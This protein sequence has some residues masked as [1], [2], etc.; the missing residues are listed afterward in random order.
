MPEPVI[1]Q[2]KPPKKT[3]I[4]LPPV[5]EKEPFEDL[6]QPEDKIN[7]PSPKGAVQLISGNNQP[8]TPISSSGGQ[9]TQR[10]GNPNPKLYGRNGWN[11]GVDI[12]AKPGEVQSAPKNGNWV[13]VSAYNKG[14]WNSGWG[15][16]VVMQ[17]TKTGETIR[18]SHLNRVY[19]K[20]G[21]VITGKPVGTTGRTGRTTGYHKDVEYT[22]NGRLSDYTKSP[23]YKG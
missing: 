3:K 17:N 21:Q 23:Y 8:I 15:N 19:V 7:I 18:R 6:L 12:S 20:K 9:I 13:V 22:R 4:V 16:S 14:G 1:T 11:R 2:Y 10:F 5:P